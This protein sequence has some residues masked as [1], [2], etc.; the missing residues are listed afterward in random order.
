MRLIIQAAALIS[1][2][3]AWVMF[4]Q[5]RAVRRAGRPLIRYGPLF[6]REQERIQNLNYIYN[7]NDVEALWMLRMKRA[8]FARLV[9]TFRSRGL[10]QDNI[11]TSVEEQ[12]AMF[13]HV[14]GHNQRFRVIHNTFKRSMETIS[15]YFK[16]VLFAVGELRGEMIR[17]PSGQTPPKIR[18]SPR[19]YPYFK[20]SSDNINFSWLDML[21][22]F[23][24][25]TNT[26]L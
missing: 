3:Q 11:N 22:L 14:V 9:E 10:L 1:V 23:K 19:W 24:L 6:P 26:G 15:R 5:Q 18:G 25:S 4:M 16:Q 21:I 7:C 13:L 20:V 2:I 8:P 17:R 12:V